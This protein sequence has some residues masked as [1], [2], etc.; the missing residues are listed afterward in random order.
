MLTKKIILGSDISLV[1]SKNE[2][3]CK[4]TNHILLAAWELN[5][6]ESM[7]AFR[8]KASR[9]GMSYFIGSESAR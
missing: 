1:E 3:N 6:S 2:V 5:F 9:V 8:L 4:I 7:Q